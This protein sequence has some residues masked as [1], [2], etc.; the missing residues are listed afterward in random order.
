MTMVK[1]FVT[2]AEEDDLRK[3]FDYL[4]SH[5]ES[6]SAS[7]DNW[8]KRVRHYRYDEKEKKYYYVEEA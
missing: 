2:I 1:R 3:E 6:R 5:G 8:M 4:V 7:F